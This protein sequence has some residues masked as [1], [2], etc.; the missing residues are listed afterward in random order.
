VW[1][2]FAHWSFPD[3]LLPSGTRYVSRF[4][5]GAGVVA[6]CAAMI[7]L[8]RSTRLERAGGTWRR[9]TFWLALAAGLDLGWFALG[10]PTAA[11]A[12][13][14]M[15]AS[16]G[17]LVAFYLMGWTT[18]I[19]AVVRT[20]RGARASE[21]LISV[22][23]SRGLAGSGPWIPAGLILVAVAAA[24]IG[25]AIEW[26]TTS[27]AAR[28][29]AGDLSGRIE[30]Y[31]NDHYPG[32]MEELDAYL[33]SRGLAPSS[34]GPSDDFGLWPFERVLRYVGE[35]EGRAP[36]EVRLRS[37]SDDDMFRVR[38]DVYYRY[39][40]FRETV[41]SDEALALRFNDDL[42]AWLRGHDRLPG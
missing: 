4:V 11:R 19:V 3:Y 26:R 1:A 29:S 33:R 37:G 8:S 12:S 14:V 34:A 13:A 2:A 10:R 30:D 32:L 23:G 35:L 7:A 25:G 40:G 28:I 42:R 15:Q 6:F 39:A 5:T 36:V 9:A 41:L 20:W 27:R 22:R 31:G 18:G 24:G 38:A 16:F 21:R 17:L